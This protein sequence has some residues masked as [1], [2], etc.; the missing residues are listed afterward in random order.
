MHVDLEI[1]RDREEQTLMVL[2]WH[3]YH[4]VIAEFNYN[5]NLQVWSFVRYFKFTMRVS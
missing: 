1:S 3:R 2:F 5:I 4:Y